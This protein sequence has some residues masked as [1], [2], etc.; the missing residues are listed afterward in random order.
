M[1][2]KR[3]ESL[4]LKQSSIIFSIK[5]LAGLRPAADP[6]DAHVFSNPLSPA[7]GQDVHRFCSARP[8]L[9]WQDEKRPDNAL[10]HLRSALWAGA[11]EHA[12]LRL[13]RP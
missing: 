1:G 4:G 11:I 12:K 2:S 7:E 8:V 13:E 6:R 5:F 10:P 3:N 9:G